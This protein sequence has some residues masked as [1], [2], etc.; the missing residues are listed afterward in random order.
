MTLDSPQSLPVV[1]TQTIQDL[2]YLAQSATPQSPSELES[3][4]VSCSWPTIWKSVQ[5]P[6]PLA[7]RIASKKLLMEVLYGFNSPK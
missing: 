6:N 4:D 7:A 3:K 5:R 2:C 1:M